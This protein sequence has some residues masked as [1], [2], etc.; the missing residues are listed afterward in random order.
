MKLF[1]F[2]YTVFAAAG[3]AQTPTIPAMPSYPPETVIAEYGDGQ[4][5]TWG[6]L[7]AFVSGLAPQIR[8]NALRDR[9]QLVEK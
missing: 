7:E 6:E 2:L 9:K 4:K 5:L 3:L 8:A 1:V